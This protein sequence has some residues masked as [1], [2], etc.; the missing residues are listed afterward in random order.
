MARNL[1]IDG[2]KLK[3]IQVINAVDSD[4][5]EY[6]P[7]VDTHDA[8]ATSEDIIE[9]KTAYVDG[10]EVVGT[11]LDTEPPYAS[12]RALVDRSITE[13]TAEMLEGVTKIGKYAFYAST[14]RT[15]ELPNTI[16]YIDEAAF[17]NCLQLQIVQLNEGITAIND[18]A[19]RDCRSITSI[20]FPS[21]LT[22]TY[23][24]AFA[25]CSHIEKVIFKGNTVAFNRSQFSSCNAI[26]FYDMRYFTS[27]PTLSS[28]LGLGHATGC[29]LI[30]PDALYDTWKAATNWVA[31]KDVV[32]VKASEYVEE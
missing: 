4:T 28:T 12:F 8:T 7:Y 1:E 16:S 20:I 24:F 18:E 26:A 27:V 3:D 22:Y 10:K 30:V 29:K 2:R 19:F 9:G 21:S 6:V 32:W 23:A 5:K 14:L 11:H 13:V 17:M 25:G 31:L 15:C